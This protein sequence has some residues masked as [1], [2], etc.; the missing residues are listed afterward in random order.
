MTPV[1]EREGDAS[2][3]AA[4]Q[5]ASVEA[6]RDQLAARRPSCRTAC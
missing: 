3:D 1:E 6:E 5:L 4:A 2:D